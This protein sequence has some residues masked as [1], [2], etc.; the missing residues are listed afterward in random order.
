MP[1]GITSLPTDLSRAELVGRTLPRAID[2]GD[3]QAA[4]AQVEGEASFITRLW[5]GMVECDPLPPPLSPVG[6]EAGGDVIA[7]DLGVVERHGHQLATLRAAEEGVAVS[8][9]LCHGVEGERTRS[10]PHHLHHGSWPVRHCL[11]MGR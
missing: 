7:T 2:P 3:G 10:Q 5:T 8:E 9:R 11:W 1:H 6:V 4:A